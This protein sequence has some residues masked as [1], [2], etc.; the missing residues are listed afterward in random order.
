MGAEGQKLVDVLVESGLAKSKREAR[1][2]IESGAVSLRGEKITDVEAAVS[3]NGLSILK[4]GKR[5]A[6]VLV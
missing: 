4:R 1:D 5:N 3:V 2:F 6:V